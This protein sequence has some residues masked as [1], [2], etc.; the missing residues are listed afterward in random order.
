MLPYVKQYFVGG[1]N[2][3]RAFRARALGPGSYEPPRLGENNFIPDQTGDVKLELNAE[4]RAKL[5][6]V[7]HWAAFVDAGN[8]WLQ[9]ESEDKPGARFGKDFLKELAVGAG[10]GLRFDFSYLVLRTD[11][12]IPLRIPYLPENERWVFDD[13]NFRDPEWRRNNLVFNLAIGYPF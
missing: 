1:P 8:I 10:L 6:S 3:L 4:Y 13:I 9:N 5:V 11:F 12:A 2:S 7:V